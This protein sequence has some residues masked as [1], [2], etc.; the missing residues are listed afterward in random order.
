MA[1]V[2]FDVGVDG[3]VERFGVAEFSYLVDLCA[4][5]ANCGP[6]ERVE[7]ERRDYGVPRDLLCCP[8][9]SLLLLDWEGLWVGVW[10]ERRRGGNHLLFVEVKGKGRTNVPALSASFSC[11]LSF[12]KVA[13]FPSPQIPC[14]PCRRTMAFE[15]VLVTGSFGPRPCMLIARETSSPSGVRLRLEWGAGTTEPEGPAGECM[16]RV[17]DRYYQYR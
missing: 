12:L 11:P 16:W 14:R 15:L 5:L 4:E 17:A 9:V 1:W 6:T 7:V 13:S 8:M 2:C 10:F 3:V